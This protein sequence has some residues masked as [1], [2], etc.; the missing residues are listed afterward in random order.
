MKNNGL[1]GFVTSDDFLLGNFFFSFT[2]IHLFMMIFF[3]PNPNQFRPAPKKWISPDPNQQM[4]RNGLLQPDFLR[5]N[6]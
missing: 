4:V 5:I 1:H 2:W 3:W 6:G